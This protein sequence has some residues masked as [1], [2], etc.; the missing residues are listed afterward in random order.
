LVP[1]RLE[2]RQVVPVIGGRNDD[3]VDVLPRAKLPEVLRRERPLV[4]LALLLAVEVVDLLLRALQVARVDVADR[5]D[6]D[7]GQP[8]VA[9]HVGV[10]LAAAADEPDLDLVAGRPT[11]GLPEDGRRDDGRR[12][13]GRGGP[14]EVTTGEFAHGSSYLSVVTQ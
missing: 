9:G 12:R 14:E 7:V 1:H 11:P 5:G 10:A 2:R 4:L 3:R 6:L 13:D 8:H